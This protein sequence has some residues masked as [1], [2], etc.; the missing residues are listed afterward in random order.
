MFSD[1]A[2]ERLLR[3]CGKKPQPFSEE[4]YQ[5]NIEK[6]SVVQSVQEPRAQTDSKKF[7][8]Y[9]DKLRRVMHH[10]ERC[11]VTKRNISLHL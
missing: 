11:R 6:R 4:A 1:S 5:Q 9:Y 10:Q 7:Q 2:H 3:F 8:D